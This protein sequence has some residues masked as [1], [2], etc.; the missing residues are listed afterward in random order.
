M[1]FLLQAENEMFRP[2]ESESTSPK[3]EI[4]LERF[5]NWGVHGQVGL[6]RGVVCEY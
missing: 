2:R 5:E 4:V 6:R 3:N 1:P